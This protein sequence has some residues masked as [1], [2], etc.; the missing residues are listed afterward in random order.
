MNIF[1]I[2]NFGM[3]VVV[4]V[5][6]IAAFISVKIFPISLEIVDIHG[7]LMIFGIASIAGAIFVLFVME[8]TSGQSLDDIEE[9]NKTTMECNNKTGINPC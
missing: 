3:G 8:E 6:N 5:N 4:F 2:R 1:Q 9:E 7:S